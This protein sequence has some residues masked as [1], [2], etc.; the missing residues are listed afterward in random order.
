MQTYTGQK[1]GKK[2]PKTLTLVVSAQS[3]LYTFPRTLSTT[4]GPLRSPP[5]RKR[6]EQSLSF[7]L[8]PW[9]TVVT[10]VDTDRG[11]PGVLAHSKCF[12]HV[13]SVL[14][15]LHGGQCY[16]KLHC[17]HRSELLQATSLKVTPGTLERSQ[18]LSSSS[19]DE[20]PHRLHILNLT[21]ISHSSHF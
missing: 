21:A 7:S 18:A 5:G 15:R 10:M 4:Q 2:I 1:G 6:H 19:A 20:D 17:L 8:H 9:L 12:T 13:N 16:F 14:A 11:L 3:H